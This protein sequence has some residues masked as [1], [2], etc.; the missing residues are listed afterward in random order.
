MISGGAESIFGYLREGLCMREF[1]ADFLADHFRTCTG[2]EKFDDI[3]ILS[4]G[5]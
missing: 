5:R 4:Q 3:I 2:A 1:D